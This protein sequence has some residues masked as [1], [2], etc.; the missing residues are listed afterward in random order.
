MDAHSPGS[1][2]KEII[3]NNVCW[4]SGS[5]NI[6]FVARLG[7]HGSGFSKLL[8]NEISMKVVDLVLGQHY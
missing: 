4:T 5:S 7:M 1:A 2:E 6:T 8:Q 3:I